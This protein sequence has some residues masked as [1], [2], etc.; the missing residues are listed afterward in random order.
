[1]Q[2]RLNYF[3]K[4][5]DELLAKIIDDLPYRDASNLSRSCRRMR[6]LFCDRFKNVK[7]IYYRN[8]S[9]VS[10]KRARHDRHQKIPHVAPE[11]LLLDHLCQWQIKQLGFSY[12]TISCIDIARTRLNR[13]DIKLILNKNLQEVAITSCRVEME[14]KHILP[15]IP[16]VTSFRFY[17]NNG[18]KLLPRNFAD[19]I[20]RWYKYD[21]R[22]TDME[23]LPLS[24]T[25]DPITLAKALFTNC[26]FGHNA[27]L[28]VRFHRKFHP[29]FASNF[30]IKANIAINKLLGV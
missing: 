11:N 13:R 7:Y 9:T 3:N 29:E 10:V 22:L 30:A 17:K 18:N 12:G 20:R 19:S 24:S 14:F 16:K 8:E 26:S 28:R 21:V 4:L 2:P 1:M 23:L 6:S 5:P 27:S 25:T 15:L